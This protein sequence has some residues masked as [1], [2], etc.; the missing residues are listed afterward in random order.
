MTRMLKILVTAL[1]VL[2]LIGAMSALA[3]ENLVVNGSTTVLPYRTGD[4]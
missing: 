2:S 3:A 1:A 4:G